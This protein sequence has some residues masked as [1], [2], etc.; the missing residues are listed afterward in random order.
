QLSS[1]PVGSFGP[2]GTTHTLTGDDTAVTQIAFDGAGNAYY[3]ASDAFGNGTFGTIN[4]TT[5]VTSRKMTALPAAHG[6]AFDAGTNTLI[7][8]GANH[9]SQIDPADLTTLK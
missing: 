6:M 4:L 7:L 3:T 9:I 8:S 2:V 1:I 5:F